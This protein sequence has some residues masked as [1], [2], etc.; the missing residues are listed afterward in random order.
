MNQPSADQWDWVWMRPVPSICAKSRG[1]RAKRVLVGVKAATCLQA[2][3][4][5]Q[6]VDPAVPSPKRLPQGTKHPL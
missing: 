4:Y 1:M 2:A 6:T 3:V 5:R